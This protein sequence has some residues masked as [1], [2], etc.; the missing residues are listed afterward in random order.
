MLRILLPTLLVFAALAAPAKAAPN[1]IMIFEAPRELGSN[2]AGL[3]A[4]TLDEIKATGTTHV[5]MILYWRNVAPGPKKKRRPAFRERDPAAY[6][7]GIYDRNIAQIRE[8]GLEPLVTIS[9]PVPRWATGKRKGGVFK[10]RPKHFRRFAEAVGLRYG[11]QVNMWS[12]WNEPNHPQFLKPQYRKK[13]G[14]KVPASPAVY[15][16][17]FKAGRNGLL[18]SGYGAGKVILA[19][20][21]APRGTPRVV[22]PVPFAKKFFKK[23]R[24][25]ASGWAHHPYT[26]KAGPFFKPSNKKD[27]TIGVLSRLTRALDRSRGGKRLP[28]YLNEFGIQSKPDPFVGVPELKQAEYR[29]ISERIAY[30]NRRVRAFSQYMM[31]DDLPR[32]GS[33]FTRYSGFESGLRHSD[34][35]PKIAYGAYSLPMVADRGRKRVTLWGLVRPASGATTVEIQYKQ[36]KQAWKRL[37]AKNT[38]AAG[39]WSTTTAFRKKRSYRVIWNGQAGARTRVYR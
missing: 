5:R 21:T 12:I 37:K 16:R 17:L 28:L 31:R 22:A 20:E 30:R 9:G 2:D 38:N 13:R 11:N 1:Q 24:L 39:Y 14:K 29:A 4:A 3:S 15:R 10:P 36:G 6:N 7:W 19:G 27:V 34:G 25:G 23:G 26:T 35:R 8:R 33:R 32:S 18:A